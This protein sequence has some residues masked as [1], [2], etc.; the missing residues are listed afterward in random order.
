MFSSSSV[1]LPR[2]T[3]LQLMI[4]DDRGCTRVWHLSDSVLVGVVGAAEP[5]WHYLKNLIFVR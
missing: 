3:L 1:A 4:E 5:R 2:A